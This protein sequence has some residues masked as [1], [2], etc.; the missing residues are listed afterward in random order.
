MKEE[1]RVCW[2]RRLQ[3]FVPR[4]GATPS[5]PN[6]HESRIQ[7]APLLGTEVAADFSKGGI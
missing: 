4:V 7:F 6:T 2:P 1:Q 5:A 3:L